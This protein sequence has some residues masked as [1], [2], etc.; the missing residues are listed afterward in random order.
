MASKSLGCLSIIFLLV[1]IVVLV[2]MFTDENSSPPASY[3]KSSSPASRTPDM[4]RNETREI[5]Q[6]LSALGYDVGVVDGILG[7]N[8]SRANRRYRDLISS[9]S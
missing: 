4:K 6:R 3:T 2:S 5:Q 7:S 8:S 9:I 1:G